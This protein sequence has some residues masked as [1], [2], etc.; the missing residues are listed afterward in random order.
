MENKKRKKTRITHT[1]ILCSIEFAMQNGQ[2]TIMF[3]NTG[4]VHEG[5]R[6]SI[7]LPL[8]WAPSVKPSFD[9][10]SHR[11]VSRRHICLPTTHIILHFIYSAPNPW[12][13]SIHPSVHPIFLSIMQDLPLIVVSIE[14]I[15]RIEAP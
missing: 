1:H 10:I 7:G 6:T 4:P 15:F 5:G 11:P 9:C 13:A 2:L 3:T 12:F 8:P 14:L